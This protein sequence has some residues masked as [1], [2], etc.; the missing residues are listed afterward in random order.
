M[1]PR[2]GLARQRPTPPYQRRETLAARGME[3]F[4][5]GGV[6]DPVT[7]RATPEGLD[8]RGRP[9]NDAPLNGDH[10]PVFIA[11]DDLCDEDMTPWPQPGPSMGSRPLWV[12]TCLANR[13]DIGAQPIGTDQEGTM[14]RTPTHLLD[15][16]THTRQVTVR[17]HSSSEPQA[18]TDHQRHSHP[19]ESSWRLD[20]DLVGLHLPQSTRLL[21]ERLL[22]RLPLGTSARQPTRHRP[23]LIAKCHDDRW[24]WTPVGHQGHHQADRLRRG[25]QGDTMRCLSW[26]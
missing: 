21:N 15:E 8:A 13:P 26:R 3:P 23:L 22:H 11:F 24:Q 1:M 10:T 7:L 14:Q 12:A 5:V 6:D 25:P 9:L 16:T 17:A 20:A 18:C 4:D 19:H 2:H